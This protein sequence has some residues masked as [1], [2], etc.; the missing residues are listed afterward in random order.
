MSEVGQVTGAEQASRTS[1]PRLASPEQVRD[2]QRLSTGSGHEARAIRGIMSSAGLNGS[3]GIDFRALPFEVAQAILTS[4]AEASQQFFDSWSKSIA[5]NA[6]A[7]KQ[8]ALRSHQQRQLM[9]QVLKRAQESKPRAAD[10]PKSPTFHGD[11]GI[12]RP[13]HRNAFPLQPLLEL[14]KGR[15]P[16]Y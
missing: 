15:Q 11:P 6:K 3:G 2:L 13:Q 12:Q 14:P 16:A 1:G 10:A 4:R 7:D 8:S 5:E 9:F